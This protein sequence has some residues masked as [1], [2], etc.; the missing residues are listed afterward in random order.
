MDRWIR[1]ASRPWGYD[2]LARELYVRFHSG[3]TYIYADVPRGNYDA[4][5]AAPSV[6]RYFSY[7]SVRGSTGTRSSRPLEVPAVQRPAVIRAWTL[8][9]GQPPEAGH[10]RQVRGGREDEHHAQRP[11]RELRA[12]CF[13]V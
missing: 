6:G 9:S 12:D 2:D 4:M 7:S 8:V 13:H 10:E 3:R 5:I 1:R 11:D